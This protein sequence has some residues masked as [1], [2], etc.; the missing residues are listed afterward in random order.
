MHPLAA[1]D[2]HRH[3]NGSTPEGLSVDGTVLRWSYRAHLDRIETL[4]LISMVTGAPLAGEFVS[5]PAS[6]CRCVMAASV[7]AVAPD[8][9]SAPIDFD[10]LLH[11]PTAVVTSDVPDG[12]SKPLMLV[13]VA[14]TDP[15][16]RLP[17]KLALDPS[18]ALAAPHGLV[19]AVAAALGAPGLPDVDGLVQKKRR[20]VRRSRRLR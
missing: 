18:A 7:V 12:G 3:L 8:P 13:R 17:G 5:G 20:F 16:A 14:A 1:V 6:T 11:D 9:Q 19:S 15:A 2:L 10:E 4:F